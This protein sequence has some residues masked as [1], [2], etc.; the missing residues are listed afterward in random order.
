M[1][2]AITECLVIKLKL[3]KLNKLFEL[4]EKE[5]IIVNS[6]NTF[7][8]KKFEQVLHYI[9]SKKGSLD[10]VG[11]T[12]L[13]KMLYFSDFDFYEINEE[14][15]TGELYYKLPNGPA[16]KHFDIAIKHLE[17]EKKIK[18]SDGSFFGKKQMK[19][20]STT[21]PCLN[22]LNGEEIKVIDKAINK[23]GEMN[24]NQISSYSHEDMPWKATKEKN[25][26]NYELVFYRN[27]I[28]SVRNEDVA[29]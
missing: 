8:E 25:I 2:H 1:L 27:P 16:P 3:F 12:V 13:Y 24:A 29:C 22:L 17:K 28:F 9:I 11:K 26:I 23:L 14:S 10:N 6:L 7:N 5:C 15:I 19:F 4:M 18:I 21:E 20:S